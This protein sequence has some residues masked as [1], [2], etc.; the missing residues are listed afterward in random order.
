[1][2]KKKNSTSICDPEK[3]NLLQFV[4]QQYLGLAGQRNQ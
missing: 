1:M 3:K 4:I 2:L